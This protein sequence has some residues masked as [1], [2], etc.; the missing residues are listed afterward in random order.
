MAEHDPN[1]VVVTAADFNGYTFDG[2]PFSH[3]P[4][5]LNLAIMDRRVMADTPGSTDYA[6]WW[7]VTQNSTILASPGDRITYDEN[8]NLGVIPY[9]QEINHG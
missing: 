7:V 1:I 4:T 5:W 2:S 9:S 3:L 8:E 6:E